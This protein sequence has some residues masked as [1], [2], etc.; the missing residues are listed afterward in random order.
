MFL[1]TS[2]SIQEWRGR[3][4]FA[5]LFAHSLIVLSASCLANVL[6]STFN[7]G[8]SIRIIFFPVRSSASFT[9]SIKSWSTPNSPNTALT[10]SSMKV[11]KISATDSGELCL[12]KICSS[13]AGVW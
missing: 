9:A 2:C 4:N 1:F 11:A 13:L 8:E 10:S 12:F 3:Q 6:S 5:P 7:I